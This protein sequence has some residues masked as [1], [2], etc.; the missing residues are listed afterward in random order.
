MLSVLAFYLLYRWD[1][2]DEPFLDFS[3]RS[4]WYNVRLIKGSTTSCETAFSYNSQREWVTRAFQYADIAS[5][6]KTYTPRGSAARLAELKGVSEDQIRR[7]GRW[8][9]EQMIGCYLNSLPREF[10]RVMAGYPS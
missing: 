9:Q 2:S 7:A 5:Q 1:L 4:T 3:E 6:Q 8:N 10:M